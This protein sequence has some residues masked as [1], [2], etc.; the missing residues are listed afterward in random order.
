MCCRG[1]DC[2]GNNAASNWK[3]RNRN[4]QHLFELVKGT[5][6]KRFGIPWSLLMME[7]IPEIRAQQLEDEWEKGNV[8]QYG[9]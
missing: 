3:G 4:E 1:G 9:T 8:E 7:E 2:Q 5:C 6:R